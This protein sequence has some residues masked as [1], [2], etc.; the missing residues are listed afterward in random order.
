MELK[1]IALSGTTDVTQN[2][3]LYEY[4]DEMIMMDCGVGFPDPDMY[5]VDL[6]I[7]DFTY[8]YENERKL[9][10]IVVTHGHEDHLGALPF[11]LKNVSAPIYATKLTAGFINEKLRDYG[12][13][14]AEIHVMDPE[15]DSVKVGAFTITPFRV[16]HS[17]PD[18][19]GICLGTPQG[20][21]FHVPD[22]KFDWMSVDKK[23]FDV[24]KA[25]LLASNGALALA[26]D[27]LG[28]TTPG[29]TS[30][31]EAI[32]GI[33][34]QIASNAT[35]HIFFTTISSNIARIQQA[36]NVA[37]R[38]NRQVC[39]L[40]QSIMRKADIARSLGYLHY[41]PKDL[42]PTKRAARMPKNKIMFIVSGSYGQPGSALYRI[43]M[44]EH[45]T[46]TIEENDT[47]VFSGDPSPPG[48]K[49]HVDFV[50]DR[51]IERGA[52][53]HYYDTQ[54]DLHVSGHGSQEDILFLLGLIK[55]KYFIPIGGT[56]RHMK[57]YKDMAV[58]MGADP[59]EVFMLSGGETVHFQDNRATK[60]SK[61]PSKEV[62]VDG[63]G[64]GDVGSM[65]LRDRHILAQEGVAIVLLTIDTSKEQLVAEPEIISRGFIFD[66]TNGSVLLDAGHALSLTLSKKRIINSG[67]AK[68]ETID[69]LEQWFFEAI[70][71]RPMILPV[72]VEV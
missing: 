66:K 16:S 24:M 41:N 37:K 46:I 30:S 57:A 26:S 2:C 33:I 68:R 52:D 67:I 11:L 21:I 40:G 56:L 44:N 15:K 36:M 31:E 49:A 35:G 72:V 59:K 53:V 58:K 5:G 7:P 29:H 63:L 8:V 62:L 61:V 1:F 34:D 48:S 42:V 22:Y 38:Y 43:A 23:P 70:G 32:E 13:K 50:V 27:C 12:M 64:V 3:Y 60:G 9:K 10:A 47:V 25:A 14:H 69:F 51:L 39:F 55:P 45:D 71:R 54:E 6:V 4:G 18:A 65:V 28:S 20:N 19:A 17:V